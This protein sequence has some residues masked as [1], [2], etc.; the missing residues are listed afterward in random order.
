MKLP[1]AWHRSTTA[2]RYAGLGRAAAFLAAVLATSPLLAQD[3]LVV[4]GDRVG[5]GTS[6]PSDTLHIRDTDNAQR[7]RLLIEDTGTGSANK[8]GFLLRSQSTASL[9]DWAFEV[10][11]AG[12]FQIDF[13]PSLGPELL[14][15]DNPGANSTVVINGNLVIN[16]SC[17]G[18]DGVFAPGYALEP[19]QDHAASMSELGYLPAVGPTPDGDTSIDVFQ[20][21]VGMLQELEKAHLYI[22][23]LQEQLAEQGKEIEVLR[24]EV[25][26][27]D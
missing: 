8:P 18:C 21:V 6:V 19:I 17:T 4:E 1:R 24:E 13:T 25:A 20:K 10:D 27:R 23:Q 26:K 12:N 22:A 9:G 2:L 15:T 16:G 14:L 5:I 7:A 3:T 11:G